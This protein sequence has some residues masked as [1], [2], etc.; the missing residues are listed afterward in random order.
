MVLAL[1][2]L[3]TSSL[4][5]GGASRNQIPRQG[6]TSIPRQSQVEEAILVRKK[7]V[8]VP[9]GSW[10]SRLSW[11]WGLSQG[12]VRWPG[13]CHGSGLSMWIRKPPLGMMPIKWCDV[14]HGR[15][16]EIKDPCDLSWNRCAKKQAHKR[17]RQDPAGVWNG[18]NKIRLAG[19]KEKL[20]LTVDHTG[21]CMLLSMLSRAVVSNRDG[22]T[23]YYKLDLNFVQ[24]ALGDTVHV[25]TV[26]GRCRLVIPEGTQT[27][28]K[29]P[30]PWKKRA[31][32]GRCYGGSICICQCHVTPTGFKWQA[33][34][35]PS[36]SAEA[37][38]V[39][40]REKGFFDRSKML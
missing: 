7:E 36:N 3:K 5:G 27:G 31:P 9:S 29:L 12:L 14:C 11:F 26:H 22:S 34:R 18:S 2:A 32:S 37:S 17:K 20:A 28:R 35:S 8:R 16:Q 13:R 4:A 24:A 21:T 39:N 25:P 10:L 38:L 19:Q 15:G 40:P 6:M 23:I 33:K 1:V 30:P